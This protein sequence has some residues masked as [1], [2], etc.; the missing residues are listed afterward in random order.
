MRQLPIIFDKILTIKHEETKLEVPLR[1][2]HSK[3]KQCIEAKDS[4]KISI[5]CDLYEH[6]IK[7]IFQ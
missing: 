3:K 7:N 2:S 1:E 6:Q 4:V 5:W